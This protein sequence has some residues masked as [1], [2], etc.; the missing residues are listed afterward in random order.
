LDKG[1]PRQPLPEE[2]KNKKKGSQLQE[3]TVEK[4]ETVTY[5]DSTLLEKMNSKDPSFKLKQRE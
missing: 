4:K 5:L 1:D 2:K 3:E